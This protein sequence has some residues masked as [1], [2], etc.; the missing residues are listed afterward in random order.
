MPGYPGFY[1]YRWY[2]MKVVILNGN[3]SNPGD[4]SW[5]MFTSRFADIS[6]YGYT[7]TVEDTIERIKDAEIILGPEMQL[8][9][10][11]LSTDK[12]LK[13][14]GALSTGYNMI[15]LDYCR[16]NGIVVTNI[17]AYGTEMVSQYA[18]ALL[19]E[20]CCRVGHHSN[21]VHE[22]RWPASGKHMFWDYPIIELRDKTVGIIGFGRIGKQTGRMA[23][24]MGMNVIYSDT[25][26]SLEEENEHCRYVDKEDVFSLSDIIMLHCPLFPE[27]KHMINRETINKM[28]D[29]VILI[30]NA[31][32]P[33]IDENALAEALKSGKIYAAGL[34]VTEVEPLPVD[35]PLMECSNC[36]IT[37]HISWVAKE[38]RARLLSIAVDNLDKYL[39]GNP[40]NRIV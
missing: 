16:E 22:G 36:F 35:S 3:N 9:R 7:N 25:I 34:D 1:Y 20:I 5:D 14:I 38:S 18:I 31:R 28:K 23:Q 10:E 4:L 21:A 11:I 27:T 6:I 26:R 33:L 40:I 29:G 17:P 15:D 12:K 8:T 2:V 32:G 13:Y 39:A 37:P 30:N 19:L 24:A